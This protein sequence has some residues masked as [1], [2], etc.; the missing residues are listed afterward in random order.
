MRI[1]PRLLCRTSLCLA[2]V[3]V[4]ALAAAPPAAGQIVDVFTK[5]DCTEATDP[6][7]EDCDAVFGPAFPIVEERSTPSGAGVQYHIRIVND[8]D[9]EIGLDLDDFLPPCVQV[10]CSGVCVDTDC[11]GLPDAGPVVTTFSGGGVSDTPIC[12]E[13]ANRVSVENIALGPG[14]EML[15]R[16]CAKFTEDTFCCNS[17]TL[18]DND[19]GATQTITDPVYPSRDETC[20]DVGA[21]ANFWK[22]DCDP[23]RTGDPADCDDVQVDGLGRRFV[24]PPSSGKRIMWVLHLEMTQDPQPVTIEDAVDLDQTVACSPATDP[25]GQGFGC[26]QVLLNGTDVTN[27]LGGD[28]CTNGPGGGVQASRDLQTGDVMEIK[29]CARLNDDVTQLACNNRALANMM[30]MGFP[31]RVPAFDHLD[32]DRFV[33]IQAE[34]PRAEGLKTVSVPAG[35]IVQP[36]DTIEYQIDLCETT[37][38]GDVTIDFTDPI[39]D[40]VVNPAMVN[41]VPGNCAVVAGPPAR[42]ECTDLVLPAGG[43]PCP[44]PTTLRWEGEIDCAGL[45]DGDEIC[46]RGTIEFVD[47]P[48]SEPSLTDDPDDPTSDADL[49][50]VTVARDSLDSSTKAVAVQNDLD[51]DTEPDCGDTLRYTIE[52]VSDGSG[53]AFAVTLSDELPADGTYVPGSTTLDGVPVVPDPFDPGPPPQIV[54]DLGDM[55]VGTTRTITFDV[56][57]DPTLANGT[58]LSNQGVLE[59]EEGRLCGVTS[60]TD[61]PAT[62]LTDEATDV[63]VTCVVVEPPAFDDAAKAVMDAITGEPIA[64]ASPGEEIVYEVSWCN[65]GEEPALDVWMSDDLPDCVQLVDAETG[66]PEI[67]V[68]LDGVAV[69][70][71]DP[72]CPDG[73]LDPASDVCILADPSQD[74]SSTE[75]HT[76]EIHVQ[77]LEDDVNCPLDDTVENLARIATGDGAVNQPTDGG[78]PSPFTIAAPTFDLLQ[79]ADLATLDPTD[80]PKQADRWGNGAHIMDNVGDACSAP[81]IER[82]DA[83]DAFDAFPFT[84]CILGAGRTGSPGAPIV[85]WELADDCSMTLRV[86]RTDCGGDSAPDI[87]V[88]YQ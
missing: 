52:A 60:P 27:P 56:A 63:T 23:T 85:F 40:N 64:E 11:N 16:F 61:D 68:L 46:N 43:D 29:F 74:P 15:V 47:P 69:P 17:A 65:T 41:P 25:L 87:E 81:R 55:P 70:A 33:C 10:N 79:D 6:C 71:F 14:E 44:N 88:S 78:T 59:S 67:D 72:A 8:Q 49:T 31:V 50:C 62:P 73:T 13:T 66:T 12:D 57:L 22:D 42:I 51:G 82:A 7:G 77:V 26:Y 38:N 54:L 83:I 32:G 45:S 37:G 5:S 76:A 48:D 18:T 28:M 58:V 86:R 19:T 36:G 21:G 30:I 34:P 35:R 80:P 9:T 53:D 20:V 39:P 1:T 3:A 4:I 2:A 24:D 84:T 75:C